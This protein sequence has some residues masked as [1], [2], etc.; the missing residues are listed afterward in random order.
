MQNHV[1]KMVAQRVQACKQGGAF[2]LQPVDCK[3][4]GQPIF[5]RAAPKTVLASLSTAAS[6]SARDQVL[7]QA[8]HIYL[9]LEATTIMHAYARRTSWRYGF[10]RT[11]ANL[12]RAPET[13][14]NPFHAFWI[15]PSGKRCI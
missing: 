8:V 1:D 11:R 12:E 6:E 4:L 2:P 9:C 5:R 10:Q 15:N 13:L 7:F 14:F 3:Q